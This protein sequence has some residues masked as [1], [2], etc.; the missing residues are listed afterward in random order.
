MLLKIDNSIIFFKERFLIKY[1]IIMHIIIEYC[2][3]ISFKDIF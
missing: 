2:E 3:D 1:P